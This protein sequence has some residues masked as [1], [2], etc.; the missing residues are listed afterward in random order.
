MKIFKCLS[1]TLAKLHYLQHYGYHSQEHHGLINTDTGKVNVFC[2]L[3]LFGKLSKY[4]DS[5]NPR[6]GYC[7]FQITSFGMKV[8]H[9]I[10]ICLHFLNSGI[11][12][13][14]G[15]MQEQWNSAADS[16]Q[17]NHHGRQCH[18]IHHTGVR[19]ETVIEP[20]STSLLLNLTC[21]VFDC[22]Q[23]YELQ[24]HVDWRRAEAAG[25]GLWHGSGVEPVQTRDLWICWV[26][27]VLHCPKSFHHRGSINSS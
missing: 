26:K 8:K 21:R 16:H 1:T 19:F 6:N 24:V 2:C 25:R 20:L 3:I 12:K 11:G 10:S 13:Q 4:Y 27:D 9:Q 15:E 5:S 14:S 23:I 18:S 7:F 17:C 22:M